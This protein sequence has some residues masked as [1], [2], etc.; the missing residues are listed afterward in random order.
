MKLCGRI[1]VKA[2]AVFLILL[3]SFLAPSCSSGNPEI[4][5]TRVQVMRVEGSNGAFA[6]RLSVFVFFD[7]TDGPADFGS[8]ILTHDDSGLTWT[9]S[10]DEVMVRL[11]GKDRWAGS[12]ALAGPADAP[13]PKGEYTIAVQDLA[14]NEAVTKFTLPTPDFPDRSPYRLSISRS[15]WKLER[16]TDAGDFSNVWFLLFDGEDRLV[17]SWKVPDA[18]KTAQEGPIQTLSAVAPSAVTAQCYIENKAGT[19]GVL[20]TPLSLR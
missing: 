16:N 9:I 19:A 15:Q 20:L 3:F 5:T 8:I 14:G 10:S 12:N 17:N 1:F 4:R 11:R 2:I 7:D 13:L 18:G 6:E